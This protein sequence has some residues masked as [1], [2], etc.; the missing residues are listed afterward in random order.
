M[1]LTPQVDFISFGGGRSIY[2]RAARRIGRD[3]SNS[4]L[5]KEVDVITDSDL[6]PDFLADHGQFIRENSRGFGYWVWKPFLLRRWLERGQS[7]YLLYCDAGSVL[8]L[9]ANARVR[10]A[11]WLEMV[12]EQDVLLFE[13]G[14]V[15][16]SWCK[17]DTLE[18]LDPKGIYRGTNAREAATILIRRSPRAIQVIGE[19]FDVATQGSYH[20]LDDSQSELPEIPGFIS[21]RHDQSI[22]SLITKRHCLS[23]C[24]DQLWYP[25]YS[26]RPE[27]PVWTTRH[28][29]GLSYNPDRPLHFRAAR[30]AERAVDKGIRIANQRGSYADGL[31]RTKN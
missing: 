24:T 13:I 4:Q 17:R 14:H 21:H 9:T 22:L 20:F 7:E 29:S 12:R 19:W 8:N 15:E 11:Q 2:R 16:A 25:E 1:H 6:P 10:F 3:A 18:L 31:R 27:V 28:L 26:S 23:P 5:F 30:I